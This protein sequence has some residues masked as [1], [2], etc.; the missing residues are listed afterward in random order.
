MP[1]KAA[2]DK[3]LQPGIGKPDF[4]RYHIANGNRTGM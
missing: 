3:A 1:A 4:G 2:A